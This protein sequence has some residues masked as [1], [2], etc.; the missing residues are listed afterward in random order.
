VGAETNDLWDIL[1]LAQPAAEWLDAF[2]IGNG[3][4]GAM[5]FGGTASERIALNHEDLWRGAT[6]DR[7]TEAKHHHLAEIREHLLAG[8][9]QEGAALAT[10]H[11][12]GHDRRVQPYQPVGDLTF[13]FEGQTVE[14]YRRSLSLATGLVETTYLQDGISVQRE[15]FASAE[16][17]V[18]VL[19]M[20][21]DRPGHLTTTLRL[22]RDI[23]S[24]ASHGQGGESDCSIA[25]WAHHH[26]IGFTGNFQEGVRFAVEARIQ[27][28]GAEASIEPGLDQGLLRVS[29]AD[30]LLIVLAIAINSTTPDP[31]AWCSKHLDTIPLDYERLYT[32]HIAEHE[33]LYR[34]VTL[35]LERPVDTTTTPLDVRMERMRSGNADPDLLAL[36]F[37][38][39][40]YLLMSSSR[41]C[42]QPAN[43]QG[44]WNEQV[45]PPWESDFHHDINLEM[46]YWPAEVTNLAEC[47]QPLFQ[48]IARAVP[49]GKK[50]A[51][52]LYDCSGVL[53][54]I[55]SDV[56]DRATPEAPG[57][58]V[59][60][61]AAAWL[62]EHLWWHW[63]YGR[64][65]TFLGETAYPFLKLVAAF[66]AD[67]LVPDQDGYLVTVP[68]QSPENV[69]VGGA[70]PVSL[71][72]TTTMD[73]LLIRE[74]LTRCLEASIILDTDSEL[75]PGWDSIL[76]NLPPFKV[77]RHGQLQEWFEDFEE[78]EPGHRHL[79]HLLGVFP[80][81]LMTTTRSREFYDAARVSLERRL[82]AGGGQSGWAC[83]WSAALWARFHEGTPA[84]SHLV[85]LI[86]DF[87]T[88]S[89]LDLYPP[90]IFQID[91]N[92]GG[93]AALAEMLLQSHDGALELLPALPEQWRTGNVTGL[94]ARGGFTVD[95]AW[96]EG[97]LRTA[98]IH[99]V[100]GGECHVRTRIPITISVDGTKIMTQ[101]SDGGG[102]CFQTEPGR[103]YQVTRSTHGH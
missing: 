85:R 30:A 29:H 73:L 11:L 6:R 2:P 22:A 71:G 78:A 13:Q 38:F 5:V 44:I 65:K 94:R 25:P 23:D 103:S 18:I 61:G 41:R 24:S 52:D 98:T 21:A 96:D 57:W 7:T 95:M 31:A 69:F 49:E 93:T 35:T 62:A 15:I 45:A 82:A 8:R 88:S 32:A 55:L 102:L 79:S 1:W 66:Y 87:S 77:G 54:P 27:V 84:H 56:W 33:A 72:V 42:S 76:M 3:S 68:S 67:Y 16:H 90:K 58:D 36:Y 100:V 46:N 70:T 14:A 34:R 37:Q 80:G 92:F 99:G 48:Y 26:A 28:S 39:G 19:R 75:R 101:A 20:R 81:D 89:L 9:W 10:K 43:L 12:S 97:Q 17:G 47:H 91:G 64:D 4:I 51:R 59:W 40:R 63:E 83:A 53:L 60:T 86:C 74:I 50:A